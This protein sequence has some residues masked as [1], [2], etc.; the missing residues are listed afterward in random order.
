MSSTRRFAVIDN[1]PTLV[2]R[3]PFDGGT[4]VAHDACRSIHPTPWTVGEER[5]D[6]VPR[7]IPLSKPITV[8]NG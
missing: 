5:R 6:C 4:K 8:A 1:L 2:D 7:S 3:S